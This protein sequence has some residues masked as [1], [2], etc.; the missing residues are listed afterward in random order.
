MGRRKGLWYCTECTSKY[1]QIVSEESR[2]SERLY[3]FVLFHET[4]PA[5]QTK[6]KFTIEITQVQNFT[7]TIGL[8]SSKLFVSLKSISGENHRSI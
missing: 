4:I 7:K 6:L 1:D 3:I 8:T 2:Q 5:Y